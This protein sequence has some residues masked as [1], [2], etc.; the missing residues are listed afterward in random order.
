MLAVTILNLFE[1]GYVRNTNLAQG[2]SYMLD[3]R[4][5]IVL[6]AEQY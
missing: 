3:I 1:V 6:E 4:N 5:V 2:S